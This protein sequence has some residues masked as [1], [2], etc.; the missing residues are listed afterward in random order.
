MTPTK[1][2]L[3]LCLPLVALAVLGLI[4][5]ACGGDG[6]DEE[7]GPLP[8]VEEIL[9]K[10]VEGVDKMTTFHFR[11]EHENG[12]SRIPMDLDLTTAEGDVIVPDR[13]W[14][15]LE[16]K[17]GTQ[18]VRVEVIGVGDDGWITNPFNREWQPLPSGTTITDIFDPTQ[19]IEAVVNALEDAQVTAQEKVGGVDTYRLEGTIDSEM[20]EGAAP[21]AEPGLTVGV[22]VWI[23]KEDSLIRRIRL[24]GPIAP[25]EPEDI[26]RNLDLSKFDEP[27]TIEPPA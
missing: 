24:E 15:K 8:S 13:M 19:G 17:A 22:K 9:T 1:R 5:A 6:E 23:G 11:L 25:D 7:T 4:L 18:S 10:A 16:A 26:V 21:I 12:A 27:V 3:V 20:L 14:A 2:W